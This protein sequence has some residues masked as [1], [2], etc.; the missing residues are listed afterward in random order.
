MAADDGNRFGPEIPEMKLLEV[1]EAAQHSVF[2]DPDLD[3]NAAEARTELTRRETERT[4]SRSNWMI[5]YVVI[6]ILITVIL[7]L[8]AM[9]YR[10]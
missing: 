5:V 2:H 8:A 6:G 1:I 3:R 7:G 4:D 9:L 10:S